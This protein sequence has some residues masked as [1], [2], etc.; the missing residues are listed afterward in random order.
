MDVSVFHLQ[1]RSG[2]HF[3]ARGIGIENTHEYAPSDTLFSALCFAMRYTRGNDALKSM[4]DLFANGEPPFLI[5]GAY[6]YSTDGTRIV[7]FFPAPLTL[8]LQSSKTLRK[9]K[10][11]SQEVFLEA[12]NGEKMQWK[13]IK[14]ISA[15]ATED[16][17]DSMRAFYTDQLRLLKDEPLPLWQTSDTT[18][19]AVDR[20]TSAGNVFRAGILRFAPGSGLWLAVRDFDSAWIHTLETLLHHLGE[21]GIGGERSSGYGQFDLDGPY[22]VPLPDPKTAFVTLSHYCPKEGEVSLQEAPAYDLTVRRGWIGSPDAGGWRRKGIRMLVPGSVLQGSSLSN[23]GRLVP[24][25]PDA[26]PGNYEIYR[27]GLAF[28][29]GYSEGT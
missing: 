5:S 20:I 8:R 24:V 26:F 19:V 3:G 29:V 21:M 6:P 11:L 16:Q 7:R 27:N 25:T 2:F 18:R 9:V 4:L 10:W 23:Y 13:D 17:A 28:P 1:P 22:T 12:V 14:G 15:L